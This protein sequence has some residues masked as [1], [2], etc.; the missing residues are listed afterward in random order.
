MYLKNIF[1]ILRAGSTLLNTRSRTSILLTPD[2][3]KIL[4]LFIMVLRA[5]SLEYRN[6]IRKWKIKTVYG[7]GRYVAELRE[8]QHAMIPWLS[9]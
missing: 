3:F 5:Q 6:T 9:T 8:M 2:V 7:N 1:R 4:S